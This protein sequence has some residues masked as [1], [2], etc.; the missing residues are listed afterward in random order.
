MPDNSQQGAKP[1][2]KDMTFTSAEIK[3]ALARERRDKY[4]L[5]IAQ[6][7]LTRQ[8]AR[9]PSALAREAIEYADALLAAVDE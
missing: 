2:Q 6:A 3:G 1:A 4:V 9:K 7:I 8:A 5:A